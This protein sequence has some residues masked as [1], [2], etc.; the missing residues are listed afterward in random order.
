MYPLYKTITYISEPLIPALL[1]RRLKR[2]KEDAGRVQERVGIASFARPAGK[3]LWI[4]AASV[5]ESNSV[6]PLIQAMLAAF[7]SIHILL[8]TVTVTSATMMQE[9]LPA[10]AFHQFTPVDTP[11][12]V[13]AFL[14][15]WRPDIALWVDSEL[16]PNILMET[17]KRGA[18]MGLINARMSE[19]S[20]RSW[21]FALPLIRPLL[22]C[23]TVCFAQS[24]ED[25]RRLL[26]L[27]LPAI[28]G[29]GNLKYDAGPL[30]YNEEELARLQSAVGKRPIW[31]AASTHPGE[32]KIIGEAHRVLK[33]EFS[34]LLTVIV[35]RH[36]TRGGEIAGELQGFRLARR[37]QNASIEPDTDIYLGDT[38]GELGL[39]YRLA[40][41]AFIGGTLVPHGGQNP[42]EAARAGCAIITGPHAHN[43]TD[44]VT[45]MEQDKAIMRMATPEELTC[46]LEQLLSNKE[47]CQQWGEAALRHV[48]SASEM[49]DRIMNELRPYLK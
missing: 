35:P 38:M 21:Q 37:S 20:F 34:N 12:A 42:L 6:L 19:K 8:T 39:F 27:G 45:R 43:F 4:H 32:E 24:A 22:S 41:I 48:Q 17:R 47:M 1:R 40:P 16:W 14:T 30:P 7:P 2:D 44:I 3:L 18:V 23:F 26:Q 13:N 36:A 11:G 25:G 28:T 15:H 31:V 46:I 10:G 9:R 33:Q 29:T 5:G 49:V